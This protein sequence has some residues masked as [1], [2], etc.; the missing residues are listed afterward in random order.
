MVYEINVYNMISVSLP[1]LV[2]TDTFQ[3]T[4]RAHNKDM[5]KDYE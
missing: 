5:L 1:M 4:I 3:H 2:Y